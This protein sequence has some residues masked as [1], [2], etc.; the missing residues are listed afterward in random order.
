[1]ARL[2][3]NLTSGLGPQSA[4]KRMVKRPKPD[5]S[6]GRQNSASYLDALLIADTSG[7]NER[8]GLQNERHVSGFDVSFGQL[9]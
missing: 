9:P 7:A 1:M 3:L 8:G 4:A 2:R 6:S 5:Q